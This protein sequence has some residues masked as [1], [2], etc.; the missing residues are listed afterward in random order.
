MRYPLLLSA[1]LIFV[2]PPAFAQHEHHSGH[3]MPAPAAELKAAIAAPSRAP[4]NVARDQYRHPAETLT[5]FGVKPGDVVVEALPGGGGWY[6]EILAPYL[7]QSGRLYLAQTEG[8]GLDN[9]KAK[10]AADATTYGKAKIS[11]F[12]MKGIAIPDGSADVVLTFRNIHNLI[13]NKDTTVPD[14]AFAGFFRALKPGGVLGIV[15]HRLPESGDAALEK[16]SGY[17]KRSTI[18]ALAEKA[19]FKLVGE[20]EINANPKDTANWPDGV[21]TLPPTFAK[22]DTDKAK[23]QAIGES[24]RMTLKFMKPKG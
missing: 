20:S 12:P 8:K 18:V 16:S 14:Q 19:G 5:F 2:A 22:G 13:M 4:A 7:A 6:T 21:W 24:D 11:E 17:L 1:A 10:L 9:L 15:D 3:V 23:Y